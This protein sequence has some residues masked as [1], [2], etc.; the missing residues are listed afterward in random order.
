MLFVIK[1][2]HGSSTGFLYITNNEKKSRHEE[3]FDVAFLSL[4]LALIFGVVLFII[5]DEPQW[6]AVLVRVYLGV[7]QHAP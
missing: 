6:I 2:L 7:G 1:C 3:G 4:I 5:Y